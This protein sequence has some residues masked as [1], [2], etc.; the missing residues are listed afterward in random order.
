[1]STKGRGKPAVQQKQ[2]QQQPPATGA[3]SV[4]APPPKLVSFPPKPTSTEVIAESTIN[5]TSS[6]STIQSTRSSIVASGGQQ[7]IT[8]STLTSVST[9]D[10]LQGQMQSLSLWHMQET[11]SLPPSGFFSFI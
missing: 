11:A 7:T 3:A 9:D 5:P 10:F 6:T 8:Q 2:Q 1:M 4:S